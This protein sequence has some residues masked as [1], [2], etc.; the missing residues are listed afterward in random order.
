MLVYDNFDDN[1]ENNIWEIEDDEQIDEE[2]SLYDRFIACYNIVENESN[3]WHSEPF[4]GFT[5]PIELLIEYSSAHCIE[6]YFCHGGDDR[7]FAPI[8]GWSYDNIYIMD[9]D[10]SNSGCIFFVISHRSN[11]ISKDGKSIQ[12]FNEVES[13][14]VD[15]R[16]Y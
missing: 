11:V 8:I 15:L 10:S 14:R 6:C 5:V 12:K 16:Q 13:T 2:T 7:E 4:I 1:P 9:V 3:C